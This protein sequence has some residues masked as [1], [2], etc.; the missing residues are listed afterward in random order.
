MS[1]LGDIDFEIDGKPMVFNDTV[2]YRGM[3]FTGIPNLLWVSVKTDQPQPN[4]PESSPKPCPAPLFTF[5]GS[6]QTRK[7]GNYG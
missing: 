7:S 1:V 4:L 6:A 2:N 3:M 5:W